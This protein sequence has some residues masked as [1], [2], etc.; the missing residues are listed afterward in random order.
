MR[1]RVCEDAWPR[2][3]CAPFRIVRAIVEAGD[4]CMRDCAGA[5]RARLER[6]RK[7]A[8]GQATGADAA[9]PLGK[10]QHLRM[11]H[12]ICALA[13]SVAVA[14]ENRAVGCAEHGA[15]GNLAAVAG[16]FGLDQGDAHDVFEHA[17]NR[18][19]HTA[20]APVR[21]ALWSEDGRQERE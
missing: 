7:R 16:A 17:D 12:W 1:R 14:G 21:S 8:P 18:R 5:H 4:S 9:E 13:H 19:R 3:D 20:G 11:G 2:N 10:D 15:H 6:N